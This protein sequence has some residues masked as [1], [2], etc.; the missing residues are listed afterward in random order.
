[1]GDNVASLG[2]FVFEL[3]LVAAAMVTVVKFERST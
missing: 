1:V 2:G 3:V